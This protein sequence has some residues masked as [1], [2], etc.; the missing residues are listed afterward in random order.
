MDWM[1]GVGERESR[2]IPRFLVG[3]T[4]VGYERNVL[5]R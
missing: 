3:E 2:M 1:P 4:G 5:R